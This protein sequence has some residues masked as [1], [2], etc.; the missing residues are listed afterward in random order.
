MVPTQAEIIQVQRRRANLN[1]GDF[2]ARAFGTSFES[3]RTKIKNI[4]LGK[5]LPT[6]DDLKK[7]ARVLGVDVAELRPSNAEELSP[8][9]T[10]GSDGFVINADVFVHFPDLAVYLDM[11]NKAAGINDVEM[12]GHI[13][14]RMA[15]IFGNYASTGARNSKSGGVG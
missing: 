7:M 10:S 15:T 13:A 6:A 14:S 4:E 9:S 3:G 11:L 12:I 2:G 1:Q 5:Q 8:A